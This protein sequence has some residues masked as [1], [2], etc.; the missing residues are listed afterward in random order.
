ML[1]AAIIYAKVFTR[2]C[3]EDALYALDLAEEKGGVGYPDER[4]W[5]NAKKMADFLCHL[6]NL[7]VRVSASLHVTSNNFLF[8]I[9]EVRI[10]IKDWMA[11][12]DP[13]QV[14]ME[15]ADERKV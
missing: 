3:E 5:Q 7:T 8:E 14:A 1:R 6:Y 13:L 4:D 9:G 12:T 10:L 11:S 15:K 2:Y